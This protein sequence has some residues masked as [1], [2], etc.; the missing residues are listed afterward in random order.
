M[1]TYI[2]IHM[3]VCMYVSIYLLIYIH[4]Y[5]YMY[6]HIY[7]HLYI[8]RQIATSYLQRMLGATIIPISAADRSQPISA[9]TWTQNFVYTRH[10][11]YCGKHLVESF[12]R[13]LT[14][15]PFSLSLSVPLPALES[16]WGGISSQ[17]A[18]DASTSRWHL[19]GSW[20]K[21]TP[22]CPWVS[23]HLVEGLRRN[24]DEVGGRLHLPL[25]LTASHTTY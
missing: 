1:Y 22:I 7:M 24:L 3:Y 25:P 21:K 23:S 15:L 8:H 4:M 2:Y 11:V 12:G 16:S 19:C 17:S 6:I 9:M 18:T 5:I 20:L 14:R 13:A 10:R